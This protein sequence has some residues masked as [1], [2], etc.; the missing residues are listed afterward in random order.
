MS[1]NYLA[2]RF[3]CTWPW[4]T[5]VMLCDGR[6]VCGCADPYGKRVLGD[7]R[8]GTVSQIWTGQVA[9]KLRW[10]LVTGGATFS[11]D[12]P[13]KLPLKKND[14]VPQPSLDVGSLPSRLYIECT[15]A[16]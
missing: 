1:L 6:L 10:P 4:S 9:S 11:G 13:L 7:T 3:T 8:T 15:A 16:C 14:P 2:T 5:M 12:C